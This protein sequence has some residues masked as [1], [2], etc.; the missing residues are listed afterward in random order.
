MGS[1]TARIVFSGLCLA[2]ASAGCKK[3]EKECKG[4]GGECS[5]KDPG[6]GSEKSGLCR[7]GKWGEGEYC[8]CGY[9]WVR[10]KPC[11]P[12][13]NCKGK[14]SRKSPGKGWTSTSY[15]DR[16]TGCKCWEE[17]VIPKQ[18]FQDPT[19]N[20]LRRGTCFTK[21]PLAFGWTKIGGCKSKD[22]SP[23]CNCYR[24][25]HATIGPIEVVA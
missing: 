23:K 18:C 21:P 5:W 12:T 7:E 19:C 8:Y 10:P 6:E 25:F 4:K 24:W 17:I 13:D 15:C 22:G 1:I 16:E 2:L 9:C 14:C 3:A 11:D 20:L